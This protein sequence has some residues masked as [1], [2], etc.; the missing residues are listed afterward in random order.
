VVV[1]G[2]IKLLFNAN[3]FFVSLALRYM[4]RHGNHS[5]AYVV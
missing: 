2:M 5:N 1:S 4:N 3:C